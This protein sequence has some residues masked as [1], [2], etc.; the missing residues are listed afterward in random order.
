M[1]LVK[2]NKVYSNNKKLDEIF[3]GRY[4]DDKELFDK[5]CIELMV[6]VNEFINETKVFKYWSVKTPNKENMLE[7]YAD[8]ITMILM[9]YREHDLEIKDSYP[10]ISD[11]NKLNIIM[12]IYRKVYKFY[13][14]ND[15]EILEEIFYY[16]LYL[17]KLFKFSEE[18][19]LNAIDNKHKIIKER[20]N[21]DY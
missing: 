7:E 21:S 11:D 19:I 17:G 16:T 10:E 1:D 8:I 9:F 14:H 15:S 18:E 13:Q 6:E 4:K 20:L 3:I 5:N 12:E 2:W